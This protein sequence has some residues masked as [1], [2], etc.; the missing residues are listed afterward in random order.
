MPA[1]AARASSIAGALD[2]PQQ[3]DDGPS[4]PSATA[5]TAN[6]TVVPIIAT[7][8]RLRDVPLART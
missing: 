6:P 8:R 4:A 2:C 3:R 5:N 7:A 1:A